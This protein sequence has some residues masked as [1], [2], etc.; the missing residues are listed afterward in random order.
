[1]NGASANPVI[2]FL[3]VLGLQDPEG[4]SSRTYSSGTSSVVPDSEDSILQGY[5]NMLKSIM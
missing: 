4:R 2:L 3:R 5:Q 1:M